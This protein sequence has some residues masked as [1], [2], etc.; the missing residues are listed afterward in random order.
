MASLHGLSSGS[1]LALWTA[2]AL[3]LPYI[4][5]WAFVGVLAGL[6]DDRSLHPVV[7]G[8]ATTGFLL[9]F[10]I[11]LFVV[12]SASYGATGSI[13]FLAYIALGMAM[14]IRGAPLRSGATVVAF[15]VFLM[16]L[17]HPVEVVVAILASIALIA[18]APRAR[19]R[20][21]I[22]LFAV[23]AVVGL[24]AGLLNALVLNAGA[25]GALT[26]SGTYADYLSHVGD[27]VWTAIPK[28]LD[29]T[30]FFGPPRVR[31]TGS[32]LL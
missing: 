3:V 32:V 4:A 12:G 25:K 15:L 29:R 21:A 20:A 19:K 26:T 5:A 18:A 17:N 11:V 7:V 31:V 23:T 24:G 6:G 8:L 13:F 1:P 9:T 22:Y 28:S 2:G 10:P 14:L 30:P 16:A 27:E